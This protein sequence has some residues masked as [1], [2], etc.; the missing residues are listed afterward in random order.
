MENNSIQFIEN[1][2][3][4][5]CFNFL[6]LGVPSFRIDKKEHTP[7]IKSVHSSSRCHVA[8][9]KWRDR[10][11]SINRELPP[12]A[13][14]VLSSGSSVFRQGESIK[15]R[16]RPRLSCVLGCSTTGL[17]NINYTP[18]HVNRLKA[19]RAGLFLAT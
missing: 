14:R 10:I 17:A 12:L 9:K 2:S 4:V 6:G 13:R 8:G 18:G 16:H 5:Q 7:R 11:K 15:Q 1:R 19:N 3:A